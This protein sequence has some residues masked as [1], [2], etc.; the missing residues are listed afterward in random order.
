MALL[1]VRIDIFSKLMGAVVEPRRECIQDNSLSANED[2][3]AAVCFPSI[4]EFP[5]HILESLGA[6]PGPKPHSILLDG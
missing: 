1:R 4:S 3:P 5:P 2:D 6:S